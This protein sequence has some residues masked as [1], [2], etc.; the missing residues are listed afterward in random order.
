MC[1]GPALQ[2]FPI[3]LKVEATQF[4]L[5]KSRGKIVRIDPL[6][7]SAVKFRPN[8]IHSRVTTLIWSIR[9]MFSML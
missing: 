5:D 2:R 8:T 9:A 4:F 3:I 6:T 7:S 1:I